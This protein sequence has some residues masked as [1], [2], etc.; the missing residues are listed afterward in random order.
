[1]VEIV[2]GENAGEVHPLVDHLVIGREPDLDLAVEDPLVSRRHARIDLGGDQPTVEDLESRNGTYVNGQIVHGRRPLA[3][4]DQIRVGLTVAELRTADQVADRP[5]VVGPRP[6]ISAVH[7][8]VLQPASRDEL[9]AP[10]AGAASLPQFMAEESEP[11]FVSDQAVQGLGSRQGGY[12]ALT[13]LIDA[14]V[15]RQTSVAA[16][17]VLAIA[18]LV[19]IVYFGAR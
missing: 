6:A 9:P 8:G 18:A 3:P 15:K 5:S 12:D 16:F 14:R 17:A 10:L 13:S 1:M 4:G 2:E 19:V 7:E 11:A